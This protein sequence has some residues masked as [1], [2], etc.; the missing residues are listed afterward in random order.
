MATTSSTALKT[1]LQIYRDCLRLVKHI[2]GNSP[3]AKKVTLIVKNEFRKHSTVT[4][5]EQV[6]QLKFNAVR[7]L[8][9]Y[10]LYEASLKEE[11][12]TKRD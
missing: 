4:D 7:A 8:S 2:A 3:K 12:I 5:A 1:S 9:N 10:L 11:R 6:H